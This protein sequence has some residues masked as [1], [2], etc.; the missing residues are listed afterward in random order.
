VHRDRFNSGEDLI[1]E[2]W[3]HFGD[4]FEG[5]PGIGVSIVRN[6]GVVVYTTSST[7]DNKVLTRTGTDQFHGKIEFTNLPLLSGQYYF[8]VVT[9]DEE[10]MQAYSLVEKAEPFTMSDPGPD[11]GLVRISHEWVEPDAS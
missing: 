9:T 3:T 8:N 6:D 10:N 2:V 5:V 4:G 11:F 7:M 1:L